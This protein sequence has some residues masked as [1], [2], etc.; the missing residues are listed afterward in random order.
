V[1]Y[2]KSVARKIGVAY[3]QSHRVFS[4]TLWVI[5]IYQVFKSCALKSWG[6]EKLVL[7]KW[8]SWHL[9]CKYFTGEADGVA[10]FLKTD[11][12]L[13][14]LGNE[15]RMHECLSEFGAPI[16]KYY[17][18]IECIG[19]RA[20]LLEAISGRGLDEYF[21][22]KYSLTSEE[23]KA[24]AEQLVGIVEILHRAGIVHRDLTP[25]NLLI[26]FTAEN[27][28]Y[29]R[30]IDL[31][32]A[33]NTTCNAEIDSDLPKWVLNRLGGEY[34]ETNNIWDDAYSAIV[35]IKALQE[36]VRVDLSKILN[37]LEMYRGKLV[38]SKNHAK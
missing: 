25:A 9:S 36:T 22:A 14:L 17:G 7:F 27:I 35:I 31:T 24:I 32:F 38:Y 30:L 8:K 26:S 23:A 5:F 11:N 18:T 1:S 3:R 19:I 34:R 33:V 12:A 13:H 28:L 21:D 4:N 15:G 16:P 2:L 29:V 20:L 10:V 37:Q 6:V